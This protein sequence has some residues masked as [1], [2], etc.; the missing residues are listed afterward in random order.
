M[1]SAFNAHQ[2][3]TEAQW[4]PLLDEW[5]ANARP[6]RRVLLLPPD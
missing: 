5:I 6:G 3:L 4:Q 2:P 1:I